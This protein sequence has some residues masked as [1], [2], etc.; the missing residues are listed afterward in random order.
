MASRESQ[1]LQVALILFV[2]VTVVLAVTTYWF[3]RQKEEMIKEVDRADAAAN[4]AKKNQDAVV[5]ENQ[6]LKHMIGHEMMNQDDY[7][8]Q[9]REC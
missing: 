8:N 2:M 9:K 5:F 7:D 1:G 6:L 4:T 3:F